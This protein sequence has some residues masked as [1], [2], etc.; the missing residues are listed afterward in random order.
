VEDG[1]VDR[2]QL[3]SVLRRARRRLTPADVGLPAGDRRRV[4]G[5]RREEVAQLA[6]VS[7]DYVV[8]LEQARGPH[9]SPQVLTALCRALRLR[10][11]ERDEVFHLADAALPTTGEID[12]VVRPSIQR[13]LDRLHD[14]PVLVIS[15][16]A[17]ILAWNELAA[18]LLGDWSA[19]PFSQRNLAWQRFLG[20]GTA[21]AT[22]RVAMSPEELSLTAK[23]TVANLRGSAAKYPND[24]GLRRLLAELRHRSEL[25][26]ELW[27][28]TDAQ[29]WRSLTKTIEHPELGSIILDCD[30]MRIP[31]SD[32]TVIVYSAEPDTPAAQ[33]LS[34]LRVIG[35]QQLGARLS[36]CVHSIE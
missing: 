24:P 16:K 6:G 8:R 28:Q 12:L 34:L 4:T 18:A 35:T 7:V 15:A 36:S 13:L 2:D 27:L 3:A 1:Q 29:G 32:Q 14:V 17:D 10:E 21:G 26:A 31:E 23:Q 22:G 5:L 30:S 33:A 9:P 19:I 11:E 20:A 25:F